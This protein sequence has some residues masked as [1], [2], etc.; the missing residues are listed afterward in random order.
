[1]RDTESGVGFGSGTETKAQPNDPTFSLWHC[2]VLQN[3]A[4][5]VKFCALT[6]TIHSLGKLCLTQS[7]TRYNLVRLPRHVDNTLGGG[8]SF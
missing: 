8:A 2:M 5:C 1:M 3:V 7:T 6:E 4:E